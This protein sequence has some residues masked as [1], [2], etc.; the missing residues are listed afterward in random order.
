MQNVVSGNKECGKDGKLDTPPSHLLH[1]KK[2]RFQKE[3][4]EIYLQMMTL[5][6]AMVM[7]RQILKR[8]K[9][10]WSL[11]STAGALVVVVI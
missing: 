1:N 3:K 11:F 4:K 6:L 8:R 7:Q 10:Y 9:V 2:E 5:T